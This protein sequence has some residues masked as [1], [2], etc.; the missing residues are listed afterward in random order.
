MFKFL[1]VHTYNVKT[2]L[3]TVQV[4]NVQTDVTVR[5]AMYSNV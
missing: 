4:F 5:D 2:Y 3:E 1:T